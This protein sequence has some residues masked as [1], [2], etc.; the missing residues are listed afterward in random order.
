MKPWPPNPRRV[1]I[2]VDTPGWFDRHAAMLRDRLEAM[3]ENARLLRDCALVEAGDIAFYL[4][5]T[6]LTPKAV[7]D[8]AFA[9]VVVHA[10][11]L[12]RGRGFSPMVWQV[13]DG[14]SIIPVTMIEP[15]L[16]ADAGPILMRDAIHLHGH[17]LNP[18]IRDLLGQKVVEMCL[19]LLTRPALPE[20]EAQSG[21]A[22]H[23]R[24]R[25]PED[26][27]LDPHRS[28]ADQFDLLRVV[29]NERYPAFFDWRGHRYILNI[30]RLPGAADKG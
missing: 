23:Y 18:E 3:G 6:R 7:L 11:D 25:V 24:R 20:G 19:A 8:R 4:S 14:C 2:V 30:D 16:E 12:P 29:D 13:L 17:E 22:S 1:A 27:R 5:C 26:S 21:T 10:S 15:L 9:N 28:L